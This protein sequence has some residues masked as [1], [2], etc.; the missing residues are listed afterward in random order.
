[1]MRRTALSI[2]EIALIGGT[3]AALGAGVALLLGSRLNE[4]QRKAVGWTLLAVGAIT[5]VPI[6]A[7]LI[8][9]RMDSRDDDSAEANLYL[10]EEEYAV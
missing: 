5:T 6:A 4:D 8:R 10:V 7:Q 9:S 3:R 2:P 1:M